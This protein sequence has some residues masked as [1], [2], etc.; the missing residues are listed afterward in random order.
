MGSQRVRHEQQGP[1]ILNLSNSKCVKTGSFILGL[2]KAS[3]TL[4]QDNLKLNRI[5]YEMFKEFCL[6]NF[7]VYYQLYIYTLYVYLIVEN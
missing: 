3:R 4:S 6:L 2:K 7:F 5:K 1:E